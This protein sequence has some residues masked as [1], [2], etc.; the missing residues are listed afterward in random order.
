MITAVFW[1]LLI[2]VFGKLTMFAFKMAWGITKISLTIFFLPLILIGLVIKGMLAIAF[3][4][5]IVIAVFT[6]IKT[7]L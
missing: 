7:V 6:L 3:P 5:L 1:I 2:M 4:I